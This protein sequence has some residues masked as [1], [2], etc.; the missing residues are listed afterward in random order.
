MKKHNL[1]TIKE[2]SNFTRVP[3]SMLR[4]YDKIGLFSP[5]FRGNNN[6]RYYAY[7]QIITLNQILKLSS[8]KVPLGQ[9]EPRTSRRTPK[10]TLKLLERQEEYLTDELNRITDSLAVIRLSKRLLKESLSVDESVIVIQKMEQLSITFAP[11][12]ASVDSSAFYLTFKEACDWF[13]E[14]GVNLC[15]PIGGYY[16]NFSSFLSN[17]ACPKRFFS[18]APTRLDLWPAGSY[19]VGYTRGYYGEMGELP[20]RLLAYKLEN[21][22]NYKGG[23]YVLYVQDEVSIANPEHYLAQVMV[24]L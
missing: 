2:F 16:E 11:E 23:V 17:S 14:N 10:S 6:Y 18:L 3:E 21:D 7:P 19:A 22:L 1:L 20:E 24:L 8:L 5:M 9:I 15:Y 4:Y 13:C 12:A